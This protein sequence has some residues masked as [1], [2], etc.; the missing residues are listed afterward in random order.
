MSEYLLHLDPSDVRR[1]VEQIT[2]TTEEIRSQTQSL[3]G[4]V[5][6]LNWSSLGR[7]QFV[8]EFLQFSR[9][10]N[11][12]ADEG[13][14]LATRVNNHVSRWEDAAAVVAS[15][16]VLQSG[17]VMAGA[18]SRAGYEWVKPNESVVGN[19]VELEQYTEKQSGNTCSLYAQGTAMRALGYSFNV[20]ETKKLGTEVGYYQVGPFD[21]SIGLGKVWDH[22]GVKYDSFSGSPLMPLGNF[23]SQDY[24][25]A[26]KFLID[27]VTANK[28][29][30]VG[31]EADTLYNGI[32]G[33]KDN[34]IPMQGHAV[35]VT[36]LVTNAQGSVT[37]VLLNDSI[38]GHSTR[39]PIDNFM[40]AWGSKNYRAIASQESIT[41][42]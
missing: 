38:V 27:N 39:V 16:S 18:A 21:G 40:S 30:I 20:D 6:Q 32:A 35:W 37:D 36:G 14:L 7:D 10:I 23:S 17:Q 11:S 26:G 31:V 41:L 5:S 1:I 15:S 4:L 9:Q 22:Y 2:K 12:L 33:I 34:Y 25:N 8:D 24:E 29:V 19:P 3:S 28:A 42:K 13:D